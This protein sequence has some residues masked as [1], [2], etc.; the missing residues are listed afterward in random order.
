MPK[1]NTK[2][3]LAG[4]DNE[5]WAVKVHEAANNRSADQE[6]QV[7]VA[8]PYTA[9]TVRRHSQTR[10][11]VEPPQGKRGRGRPRNTWRRA[12]PEE[13][14]GVKK[15]WAEIKSD[16]KNRVRCRILVESLCSA[17]EW[18]D[19]IYYY[20]IRDAIVVT[21]RTAVSEANI[22]QYINQLYDALSFQTWRSV[23]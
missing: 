15:T 17:A 16:A 12:V 2:N 14:K 10:P 20:N 13:T 23:L 7:G 21:S 18:R 1:K 4:P 19:F 5:K 3:L 22:E 11:R 8:G 9:E 6:T